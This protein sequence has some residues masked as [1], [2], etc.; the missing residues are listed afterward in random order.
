[1][2][3]APRA[4]RPVPSTEDL[5]AAYANAGEKEK[6]LVRSLARKGHGKEAKLVSEI[7]YY[8]PGTRLT[9]DT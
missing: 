8:F 3:A 4:P 5:V 2:Q 9:R 7:L 6:L 1:M